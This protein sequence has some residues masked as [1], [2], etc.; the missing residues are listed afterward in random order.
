MNSNE[1][2]NGIR[3][4]S[5]RTRKIMFVLALIIGLLIVIYLGISVYAA[6]TIT[7]I[8]GHEQYNNT[9]GTFG[10]EYEDVRLK[11]RNDGKR[12]AAWYI[13]NEDS[14][15]AIIMVHGYGASKQNAVSGNYPKLAAS[16]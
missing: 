9:P 15:Q 2:K 4:E 7:K 1:R 3:P 10:V 5:I 16:P 11:A 6:Y 8:G 14:S 13:P 12:I